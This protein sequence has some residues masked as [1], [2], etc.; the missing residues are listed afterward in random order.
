[1]IVSLINLRSNGTEQMSAAVPITNK[2]LKILLPTIF[3]MAIPAFPFLAAVTDVTSSGSDVPF[4]RK[5]I[6]DTI[7]AVLSGVLLWGGT[8]KKKELR[9]PCGILMLLGYAAYFVYLCVI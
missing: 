9:K 6:I 4:E 7:I 2:I 1:M 5:F 3:P 8:I